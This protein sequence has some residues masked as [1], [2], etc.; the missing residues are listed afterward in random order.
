MGVRF[1]CHV[2]QKP[3]NIKQELAG[4]RGVCPHCSVRFRIP[5]TDAA[6]SHPLGDAEPSSAIKQMPAPEIAATTSTAVLPAKKTDSLL[7]DPTAVWYVRPPGGG[8]YGPA[9]GDVLK[10]WIAEARITPT[11]LVWRDGWSQ[12]RSASE[13]LTEFGGTKPSAPMIRNTANP[14]QPQSPALPTPTLTGSPDIG[15][16]RSQKSHR[17]FII[18]GSLAT[19]CMTLI[20][21]L[22]YLLQNQ[23]AFPE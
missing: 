18:V 15:S 10:A 14:N 4:K 16:K 2:C 5:W 12:W 9:T 6:F 22:I 11:S 1:A 21:L 8:Q 7:D 17:R 19:I 3:L 13:A 23:N 20:G